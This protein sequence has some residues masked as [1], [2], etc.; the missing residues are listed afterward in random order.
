MKILTFMSSLMCGATDGFSKLVI[1][2]HVTGSCIQRALLHCTQKFHSG[3][4]QLMQNWEE[5]L[6]H[7]MDV[8]PIQS[9][10]GRLEKWDE[11]NVLKF[12]KGKGQI[13]HERRSNKHSSAGPTGRKMLCTGVLGGSWWAA[14]CI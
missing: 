13:L 8:L 3:S 10:L 6:E 4:W 1:R 14:S 2:D 12:I 7:Q 9:N 5:W 11:R